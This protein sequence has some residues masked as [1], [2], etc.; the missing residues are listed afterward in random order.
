MRKRGVFKIMRENKYW[1]MANVVHGSDFNYWRFHA[2]EWTVYG[3]ID[4]RL[5]EGDILFIAN[6][7]IGIYAWGFL[8]E[9]FRADSDEQSRIKISRG[10]IR[11]ILI[12]KS[13]IQSIK[14]LSNL[15]LFKSGRFTFL[16][17]QQVKLISSLLHG[18]SKPPLPRRQQ[19]ILNQTIEENE[20]LYTE[21]KEINPNKIPDVSY[22]YA[23]AF[24]NQDGGKLYVGIRDKDKTV[25]GNKIEY[26]KLDEIGQKVENKL[27]TIN[28]PI[29]P[30]EDY[31]IA[32]HPVIDEEGNRIT[33]CIVFELEIK[34]SASKNFKSQSGKQSIKTFSGKRKI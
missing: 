11:P 7:E 34:P 16:T 10:A 27:F 2:S 1:L 15:L 29:F 17:N 8:T 25:V 6:S 20:D 19:F 24:L 3:T 33:D 23:Q 14:E 5:S 9:I 18:V 4:N 28:P 12:G 31:T 13:Q 21:F 30:S 32:F 22:D 26:S